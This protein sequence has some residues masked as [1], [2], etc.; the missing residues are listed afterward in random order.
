MANSGRFIAYYRVSTKRQGRSGLG[1]EAQRQAV[2][3]YLN[4]GDWSIVG[5][6]TEIESGRRS[7]RPELDKAL[8]AARLHRAS[9][10]VS[11]VD[12]LT[13]SVSFLSK[14]LD[15]NVDVRFADLPQIEGATGRFLLQQMVAVAELEVSLISQRTRAALAAA[16]RRGVLLGGD[17]GVKP[18][19]KMRRR[20]AEIRQQRAAERA[21]DIGPTIA[22]IQASG[23]RSLRAIAA[24]LNTKGIPTA[25]GAGTWN[26]EQVSRVLALLPT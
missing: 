19:T 18:T 13:R 1:L 14:L 20:S 4:G 25:R 11:K 16:R 17:R 6:F 9:L 10:V 3:T 12:R 26:A 7:D 22:S 5:E 2:S 21:T 24:A 15:A 8:S 23:A